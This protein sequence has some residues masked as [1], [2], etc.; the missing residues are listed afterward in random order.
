MAKTD[1]TVLLEQ[2]IFQHTYK[3]G[4]FSCFEV[5][6]GF[7]GIERVDYLTYDTQGIWRCYEIKVSKADFY[8]EAA[9]TF[10]GHYNYYV[11]P[12]EL[13]EEV[14]DDIP[15]HIGV[16]TYQNKTL[17]CQKKS[18]RQELAVDEQ[19][20]KDS[21]IRSLY[22]E[23]TKFFQMSNTNL[24][25]KQRNKIRKLTRDLTAERRKTTRYRNILYFLSDEYDID[26]KEIQKLIGRP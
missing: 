8:S 2:K 1:L 14:K 15:K 20:L 16:Y 7:G 18:R 24:V 3:T 12:F 26:R 21:L 25:S 17:S 19:V 5:T 9:K 4:T 23:Y 6:I 11:M 22:R 10:V 13:Y